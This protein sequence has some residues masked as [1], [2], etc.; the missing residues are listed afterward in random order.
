MLKKSLSLILCLLLVLTCFSACGEKKGSE[1]ALVYPIDSDP[2]YLDPQIISHSGAKNIIANCFEGLVAVNEKGEIVPAAAESWFVSPD[3]LTYTFT[4][5]KECKWRVSIYA[6]PLIGLSSKETNSLPVTAHD[7]VFG[8]TRALLPETKSPGAPAL[9]AIEN[10]AQVYSGKLSKKH[11]GVKALDDYTLEIKLQHSDPDFL[12]AL[13]QSAAM[14]C[15]ENFFNATG[16]RYGLAVKY[17]IYNGPFY[18]N[19]WVDDASLSIR[20]NDYYHSSKEVMPRSVYFSILDEQE[21]RLG[22]L[23][24]KTYSVSPL[25]D[26]QAQEI[27][28]SKKYGLGSLDSAVTCLIFNCSDSVLSDMNIRRALAS[29]FDYAS[30]REDSGEITA[31][32]V[33]PKG[34]YISSLRYRETAKAI[35]DYKNSDPA[36]LFR[37]GLDR[38]D[39]SSAELTV[40]CSEANEGVVRKIMQSWQATLGINCAIFVE[41]VSENELAQRVASRN[42]QIALTDIRYHTDTAFNALSRFRSDS[43]DNVISLKSTTYD[44]LVDSVKDADNVSETVAAMEKCEE[45][46][47]SAAALI[48]LYEKSVHYGFGKGVSGVYSCAC[49]DIVYFKNTLS[50]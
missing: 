42:Y 16:G 11:L 44:A 40:L 2:E 45:Y 7:F 13:T 8:L 46:L 37:K 28:G 3:G 43:A 34:L 22:K 9:L 1:A 48:P 20:K 32:G 29:S 4:I 6:G 14:P 33:I 38:L 47:V 18:L 21:T 15:N 10:A 23:K 26:S 19:N 39:I 24:D 30:L 50:K 25:S 31:K 35:A 5:R 27:A 41:A 17:L 12:Y 36:A 49:G